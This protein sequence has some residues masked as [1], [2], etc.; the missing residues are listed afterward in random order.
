MPISTQKATR[1][2]T[3]RQEELRLSDQEAREENAELD[4]HFRYEETEPLS[5]PF[6]VRTNPTAAE[7]Q[8]MRE[9]AWFHD[10][11]YNSY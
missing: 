8:E 4:S 10:P 2:Q 9:M 1:F 11:L 7:L 5:S 6:A 3:S